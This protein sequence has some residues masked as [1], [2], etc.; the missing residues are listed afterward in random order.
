FN[1]ELTI[2][3]AVPGLVWAQVS[4]GGKVW[5]LSYLVPPMVSPTHSKYAQVEAS[6]KAYCRLFPNRFYHVDST[7]GLSAGFHLIEGF[8]RD[9]KPLYRSVLSDA[10]K[11]EL[12]H[13][14]TELY[15]VTGIWEKGLRG[16]VFFE[17][18]ERN[19][20]K[21]TDFDSFKEEDPELVKDE[22]L[23]RFK[24][25]Y[26]KRSGVKLTGEELAKHP[27]S[28]FF[29]DERIGLRR[30]AEALK[31][32]ETVYLKDLLVF[33][34]K[35]YRRPLTEAEKKKLEAFYTEV[36]RDKDHGIEAAVRASIVRVLVS[37]HFCLH[38][39]AAPAGKSVAPLSDLALA[40]RLSYFLWA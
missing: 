18:S 5:A 19:F 2:S 12:D 26:L 25:V 22:T 37:P 33:A 11:R 13:L 40:S 1:A 16:F 36:C 23:V 15:F 9:D 3:K 8:F 39:A 6:A 14:W 24:E 27:I 28:V 21:H 29:E 10:E 7:R 38:F 34:E 20:L 17:R 31:K 30:H 4:D 35:A 32:N